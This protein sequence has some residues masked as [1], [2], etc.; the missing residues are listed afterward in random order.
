MLQ[1]PYVLYSGTSNIAILYSA[2][3]NR[4]ILPF[5]FSLALYNFK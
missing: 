1:T 3:S 4:G 2:A 5:V